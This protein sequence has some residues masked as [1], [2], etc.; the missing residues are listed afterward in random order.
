M[1]VSPTSFALRATAAVALLGPLLAPGA[2]AQHG[3]IIGSLV[4]RTT[5]TAL[6]KGNCVRVDRTVVL[7][8]FARAQF[9]VVVDKATVDG[10]ETAAL[11]HQMANRRPVG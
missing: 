10:T 1:R 8:D 4:G 6:A 9:G 2:V 3:E 11:R 7:T 5:H